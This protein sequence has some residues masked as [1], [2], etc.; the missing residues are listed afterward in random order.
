VLD[1]SL[2]A[3]DVIGRWAAAQPATTAGVDAD[4]DQSLLSVLPPE[5]LVDVW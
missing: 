1:E 3:A 5:P 4:H 2:H